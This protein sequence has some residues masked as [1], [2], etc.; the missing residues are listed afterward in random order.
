M[1]S[2]S[3]S[4]HTGLGLEPKTDRL[5]DLD[6]AS[7]SREADE[8]S[9]TA[10]WKMYSKA[11][12]SLPYRSR[13]ENLTWRLM[14]INL[15]KSRPKS[16]VQS[17]E[18]LHAQPQQQPSSAPDSSRH[19]LAPAPAHTDPSNYAN[20]PQFPDLDLLDSQAQHHADPS[21][22]DFDYIEHIK[23]IGSQQSPA[24]PRKEV[25]PILGAQFSKLSQTFMNSDSLE[26][27]A[28]S[29]PTAMGPDLK[30]SPSPVGFDAVST[31]VPTSLNH[32]PSL[33]HIPTADASNDFLGHNSVPNSNPM[34]SPSQSSIT[35]KSR[36]QAFS[37]D[38]FHPQFP[39]EEF[40]FDIDGDMNMFEQSS[41][42]GMAT[43][44]TNISTPPV[45]T[46]AKF[47]T[48][49]KSARRTSV[50]AK[51]KQPMKRT[52]RSVTDV[53]SLTP[54]PGSFPDNGPF[55][56]TPTGTPPS[57]TSVGT[58]NGGFSGV[59]Q[60]SIACTNCHTKTTPLWRRNPEGQPLCNACGLFLK[61]HG[62]V[63]PLSLKTD[64]I[65][66]RQRGATNKKPKRKTN[67]DDL[68]PTPIIINK[69]KTG[70]SPATTDRRSSRLQEENGND[71]NDDFEEEDENYYDSQSSKDMKALDFDSI[72]SMGAQNQNRPNAEE[73][74][75]RPSTQ[76]SG[77]PSGQGSNNNWDWLTMS[78]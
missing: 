57:A 71:M 66:K 32:H 24:F 67:G 75:G 3:Q 9:A 8:S 46:G 12:A 18:K 21:S 68:N 34:Y 74:G 1:Y 45:P 17:L 65:K 41:Q 40:N 23:S 11:K 54:T 72:L 33:S 36:F 51:R 22:N 56:N 50:A 27:G 26:I 29:F 47:N 38:K 6:S 55:G 30:R 42:L 13:M 60:G 14:F 20:W 69:S 78:L 35:S 63:R 58:P 5:F 53:S 7:Q 37:F 52:P 2:N 43:T 73:N 61:L 19:E 70:S 48:A 31:S 16:S 62:V 77:Q 10:L 4:P 15:N 28:S 49:P 64:V 25:S 44:P 59:D 39:K 76:G